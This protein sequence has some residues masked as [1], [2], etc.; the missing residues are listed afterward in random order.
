VP[1]TIA[2]GFQSEKLSGNSADKQT[3]VNRS[4]RFGILYKRFRDSHL[5]LSFIDP[6]IS[7]DFFA[8]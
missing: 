3:I 1:V 4:Y 8:S 6:N 7:Q 2:H 5:P